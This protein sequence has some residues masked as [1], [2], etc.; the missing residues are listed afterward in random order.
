VFAID[1]RVVASAVELRAGLMNSGV[2]DAF[3]IWCNVSAGH[4]ARV[5]PV[6]RLISLLERTGCDPTL[7]GI[8]ITETAV[9]AD[10]AA[11]AE[12]LAAARRLGIKVALDDFG[13]GHSSL[14]LLHSL[15]MDRVKI[16]RSFVREL[17]GGGA[18]A[19]IVRSVLKLGRD[20]GLDV[21]AEGVETTDQMKLLRELG[22]R[23]A[24]GYL[25]A[26]AVPIDE[27]TRQLHAQQL[28]S[29]PAEPVPLR[30]L[31]SPE[32]RAPSSE[33]G[34]TNRPASPSTVPAE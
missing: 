11:A 1:D 34:A 31:A 9:L 10:V 30:S 29:S 28:G 2:D 19:A 32:R 7:I 23:Y 21:V 3:R 13:T 18:A 20:L 15:P 27:L 17:S 5:K 8:E 4:L 25:F 33:R 24:Q 14:T 12:E 16:D 22:C 6:E 26:R